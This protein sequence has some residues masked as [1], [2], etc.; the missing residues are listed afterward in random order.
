[1]ARIEMRYE[2]FAPYFK[3]EDGKL[4]RM[5]SSKMSYAGTAVGS[6]NKKG[7]LV[8]GHMSRYWNVHRVIY[9]LHY[10]HCPE[11]VDHINGVVDDNRIENLREAD[12]ST[13]HYNCKK[14]VTNK[15]GTK[16]VYWHS[17]NKKWAV[18]I[19]IAGTKK[20]LG[21]YDDLELAELVATEA[22]NKFHGKFANHG[23]GVQA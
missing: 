3:Y 20:R 19:S 23:L 21:F 8:F 2:D 1:M 18:Q 12:I 15:S 22:R 13:N 9:L 6:K 16:G 14:Y 17:S 11:F 7:Y 4:I 5:V 10:G